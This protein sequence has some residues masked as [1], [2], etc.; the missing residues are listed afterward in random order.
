MYIAC[1][2]RELCICRI[3]NAAELVKL[4]MLCYPEDNVTKE[5]EADGQELDGVDLV[6]VYK[7]IGLFIIIHELIAF[8]CM[9]KFCE[10]S[11]LLELLPD[12]EEGTPEAMVHVN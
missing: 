8:N 10:H 3:L 11:N 1:S 6:K 9:Q 2:N 5:L 4:F 12:L 7:T